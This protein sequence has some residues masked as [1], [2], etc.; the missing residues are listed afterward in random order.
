MFGTILTVGLASVAVEPSAVLLPVDENA[1]FYVGVPVVLELEVRHASGASVVVPGELPWPDDWAERSRTRSPPEEAASG[2][3]V[4]RFRFEVLPFAAGRFSLG[5]FEVEV[6]DGI[7]ETAPLRLEV[8]SAL[9]PEVQA[10]LTASTALPPGQL[11]SLAAPDPE[12]A[13]LFG[14]NLPL[15]YGLAG[16]LAALVLAAAAFFAW[17]RRRTAR[18]AAPPRPAK[19][20]DLEA[21]EALRALADRSPAD[22]GGV[23]PYY[24]ELSRIFRWYLGRQFRFDASELTLDELD[25]ALA[26][27]RFPEAE[28]RAIHDLLEQADFAKFAR[29]EPSDHEAR[30]TARAAIE[31]VEQTKRQAGAIGVDRGLRVAASFPD[32]A[33]PRAE[34]P[35]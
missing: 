16:G 15:L 10:A 34:E 5:P 8:R 2:S 28:R 33:E 20:P 18:P 4:E 35:S 14:W 30:A 27:L 23:N 3:R 6:G 7:I 11:E 24:T 21:I 1:D 29:W 22:L 31:R 13:L 32:H 12:P 9:P 17:R 19:A 25:E 26:R